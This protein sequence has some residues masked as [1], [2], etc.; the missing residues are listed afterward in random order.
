MPKLAKRIEKNETPDQIKPFA[1]HGLD[2]DWGISGSEA[3]G[4]CVFCGKEGKFSVRVETG[5]WQCFR[6]GESGGIY[7]FLHSFWNLCDSSTEDY[8]FILDKRGLKSA[9]T[10]MTWGVCTSILTGKWLF[11][12]WS[13]DTEGKLRLCQL[14]AYTKTPERWLMYPTPQLTHGLFGLDLC[15]KD[16]QEVYIAEGPWDA[17]A[18][19]ETF[20]ALRYDGSSFHETSVYKDSLLHG[21]N[22]IG[23]ASTTALNKSLTPVLQKHVKGKTVYLWFDNDY[24]RKHPKSGELLEPAGFAGTKRAAGV[25]GAASDDIHF[26]DWGPEGYSKSYPDGFDVGDSIKKG[27]VEGAE[28]LFSLTKPASSAWIE[29]AKKSS[30]EIL[31][32]KP[33][34]SWKVLV[35]SWRKAMKWSKGL[36]HALSAMLSGVVS[37]N[38]VGDQLWFKIIGPASCGKSTLCEAVSVNKRYVLPKSTIRGFHSG[39]AI[40]GA[41]QDNSLISIVG[42]MTLVTKDG[43]TLL[44]SPNK[45]QI[46]SEARDV[47][48]G[49]SRTHYRNAVC[50]DYEGVR[51]TWLLCGTSRL[52]ELDTSE[53]GQ[54]FLDCVIM[55]DI[56]EDQE[57]EVLWRVANKAANQVTQEVVEG[58]ASS[59]QTDEMTEAMRLTGGYIDW[60]KHNTG[61]KMEEVE[62]SHDAL[63]MCTYI[64]K[65]VAYM[66]ARP[67]K[68]N[69]DKASREF[70]AR[71]VSQHTRFA[72]CL[73][74][75]LNR[76]SVD[77]EV[78]V[79]VKQVGFDTARGI[80]MD[81]TR[82][83]YESGEEGRQVKSIHMHVHGTFSESDI[84]SYLRFMKQIGI[85]ELASSRPDK[86]RLTQRLDTLCSKLGFED[87]HA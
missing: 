59:H 6:C 40:N 39:Y 3:L 45:D 69:S 35:N 79:R 78:L 46:L 70:G 86:W 65:F 60:L 10:L 55:E 66:R 53:L 4:D 48:D 19:W 2:L 73:A 11:P 63:R 16:K 18:L 74:L 32:S 26:L 77:E 30:G 9:E 13:H 41:G 51:M 76:P 50:K 21:A 5:Q 22:I 29:A 7:K 36:E 37:T 17:I 56:D 15:D 80:V 68:I 14:Y 34:S 83:L 87:L 75:V 67:S 25:V 47:Y 62:I 58:D 33:C 43:D 8:N 81:I 31:T 38:L 72:R 27:F 20:K 44:Q 24:P 57:D 54:R 71:L 28:L 42:G 12:A 23:V 61:P 1:F 49:V 85:V 84:R 52:R 64:G 82:L